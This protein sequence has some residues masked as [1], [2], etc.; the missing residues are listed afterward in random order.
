MGLRVIESLQLVSSPIVPLGE[1]LASDA[2]LY[3]SKSISQRFLC[4]H[5]QCIVTFMLMTPWCVW[6]QTE[7]IDCSVKHTAGRRRLLSRCIRIKGSVK[8]LRN[9][10]GNKSCFLVRFCFGT[11][12]VQTSP[13]LPQS[14]IPWVVPTSSSTVL[15]YFYY[16]CY[17]YF[18]TIAATSKKYM[19]WADLSVTYGSKIANR[20][21]K[22]LTSLQL[23]LS[24]SD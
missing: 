16:S 11:V 4:I 9:F 8:C 24:N 2:Y 12:A 17:I 1:S 23:H 10:P 6:Q 21:R 19:K 18:E 5:F 7:V 15:R 20:N 13:G 14:W 3:A 22:S